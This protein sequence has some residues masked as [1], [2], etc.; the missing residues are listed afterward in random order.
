[1]SAVCARSSISWPLEIEESQIRARACNAASICSGLTYRWCASSSLNAAQT[2]VQW[3]LSAGASS[4]SA[5]ISSC[6][7][8]PSRSSSAPKRS[9]GK[10]L[11]DVRPV[12]LLL[13]RG[14][15]RELAVLGRELGRRGDLDLIDIP[16]RALRKRR[17]PPQRLDLDV[18][19][20]D[21]H[22]A[23]LGGGEDVEQTAAQRELPTLLDLLDAFV[24][25]RDEFRGAFVEVEQLAHA[26]RERVRAQRRVGHLLR[27]RHR[28]DD[29]DR[30]LEQRARRLVPARAGL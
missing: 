8:E 17:E 14:D 25:G 11:G 21:P 22:R 4:S 19:H 18:E 10:Q 5:A 24:T 30:R 15:L 29:D 1:M 13:Q 28:A 12:R 20:V 9:T 6:V 3:S 7:S 23:L 27:E 16:E 26:Q 2:S